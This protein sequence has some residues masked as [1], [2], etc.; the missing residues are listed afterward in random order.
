MLPNGT[1]DLLLEGFH[2]PIVQD[3]IRESGKGGGLTIYVNKRV[4]DEDDIDKFNPNPEPNNTCGEFQF[5]KIKNCKQ[6]NKNVVIG[7]VYRSPNRNPEQFN[8]LFEIILQKFN[9]HIKKKLFYIVGDF[10]QDLI[11][12]ETNTTCQNLVDTATSHGLVQLV[13][14]PTRLTEYTYTLIDHVYTNNLENTL[15]CK[16]VT[17]DLSDHLA[18]HTRVSLNSEGANI[19]KPKNRTDTNSS[20][21]FRIYNEANNYTFKSLLD[22]ENWEK[23]HDEMDAQ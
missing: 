12:Y 3:P 7:N 18:I 14:R 5:I 6:S 9:R 1:D 22:D 21:E 15:S 8:S 23:L 10:N 19:S 13:S 17:L 11:K 20:R 16:I 4:C 2:E